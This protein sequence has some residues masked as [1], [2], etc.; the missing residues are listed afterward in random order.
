MEQ[1]VGRARRPADRYCGALHEF[2][3]RPILQ[4]VAAGHVQPLQHPLRVAR[5]DRQLQGELSLCWRRLERTRQKKRRERERG[6]EREREREKEREREGREKGANKTKR[7]EEREREKEE[8]ANK[9]KE[10]GRKRGKEERA[11]KTK[12]RGK[13]GKRNS[14]QAK[15][16]EREEK[17][18]QA[19]T[20]DR[21]SK[22]WGT[23]ALVST[24]IL[25]F[26]LVN[27]VRVSMCAI[28][29]LQS[30]RD[31]WEKSYRGKGQT[32]QMRKNCPPWV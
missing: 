25:C 28:L 16:K 15:E 19:S 20:K 5:A 3:V 8:R 7:K 2:Y 11:N 9:T 12:W 27:S 32:F 24:Y 4:R 30:K 13:R 26:A 10:K 23:S 22:K 18:E 17:K 1:A 6:R 21:S 14:E 31:K 29:N